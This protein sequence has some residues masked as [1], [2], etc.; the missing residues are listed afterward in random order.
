VGRVFDTG[1]VDRVWVSDITYLAT[2]QGWLYLAAVR[3]GCS[4]RVLGHAVADHLRAELVRDALQQAIDLRGDLPQQVVFHADRGTQY[5]STLVV[6][7]AAEHHLS[8]SVGRTG[9]CWDNAMAESFWA[10]L[11][12]EHY[13]RQPRPTKADAI[14]GIAAY[15]D[16]YN[17]SRRHSALG[18]QSPIQF[19]LHNHSL[20]AE[21]A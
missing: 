6:D 21:A 4:R 3:D 5:T 18:M 20:A 15:I 13:Y 17:T 12:V 9:V 2:S 1:A 11:K 7:F 14:A 10:S 8:C 19:E 16:W